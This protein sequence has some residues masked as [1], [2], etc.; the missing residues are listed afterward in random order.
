MIELQTCLYAPYVFLVSHNYRDIKIKYNDT[1]YNVQCKNCML[2]SCVNPMMNAQVVLTLKRPSYIMVPVQLTEPWYEEYGMQVLEETK[3]LF[4]RPKRFVAA[5]ILGISALITTIASFSLSTIALTQ[6]VHTAKHVNELSKNV[7]L[8]LAIQETID[9]NL[10]AKLDV[11]EEAVLHI[12]QELTALKVQLALKCHKNY[13]W[14]C[15]TPAQL[16][17]SIHNWDKIRNHI[18]GVWNDSDISLDLNELHKQIHTLA[19]AKLNISPATSALDF[20]ENIE[21]FVSQKTIFSLFI[22]V[23]II[24][25]IILICIFLFP[26]IFRIIQKSIKQVSVELHTYILKNKKGGDVGSHPDAAT[27]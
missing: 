7:S 27:P 23:A 10:E 14:I 12:G 25:G 17:T 3:A 9:R 18:L 21:K 1:V 19:T 2:A 13:K 11:L 20:F 24:G 5:L 22:N 8:T 26:V 4:K 15:V 16:N 6:E